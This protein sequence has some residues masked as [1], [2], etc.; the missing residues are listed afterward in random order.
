[1]VLN[2]VNNNVKKLYLTFIYI[3]INIIIDCLYFIENND[4]KIVFLYI[5]KGKK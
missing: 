1:M 2:E 5:G 3:E 4:S